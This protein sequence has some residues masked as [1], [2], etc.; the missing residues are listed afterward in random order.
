M[1]RKQ[2]VRQGVVEQ[3]VLFMLLG[4][5]FAMLGSFIPGSGL[6]GNDRRNHT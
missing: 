2:H 4:V 6:P 1:L 5:C 3:G